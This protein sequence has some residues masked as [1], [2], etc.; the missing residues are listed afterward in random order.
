[1]EIKP[2]APNETPIGVKE[3]LVRQRISPKI[4]IMKL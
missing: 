4:S 2:L 3:L 1:M